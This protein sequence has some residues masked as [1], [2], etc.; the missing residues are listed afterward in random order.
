[1][2][3]FTLVETDSSLAV[4]LLDCVDSN[5]VSMSMTVSV[6]VSVAVFVE[7]RSLL[8]RRIPTDDKDISTG[9]VDKSW[10][11]R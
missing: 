10:L 4:M 8:E 6:A 1:M 3:V 11:L 9:L 7:C 2:A 5:V